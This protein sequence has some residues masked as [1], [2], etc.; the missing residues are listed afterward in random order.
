MLFQLIIGFKII[1]NIA[2][3]TK[4]LTTFVLWDEY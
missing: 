1:K 4:N 2:S 3:C